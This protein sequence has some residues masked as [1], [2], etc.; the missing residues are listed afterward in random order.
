MNKALFI[1]EF[2]A[3][4]KSADKSKAT[5]INNTMFSAYYRSKEKGKARLDFDDVIFDSDVKVIAEA[6]RKFGLK[7][8]TISSHNSGLIET[9]SKFE[10]VGIKIKGMVKVHYHSPY[11]PEKEE[12]IPAILMKIA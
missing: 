10:E 12:V 3:V 4:L 1:E 5:V 2:E 9:L 11:E 7:E 6:A 8:F